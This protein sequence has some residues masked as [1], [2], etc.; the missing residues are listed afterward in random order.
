M[1]RKDENQ[2][3]SY[4]I[5]KNFEEKSVTTSGL[6]Y[7][8]II[9]AVVIVGAIVAI[10]WYVPIESLK[11]K[12]IIGLIFGVPLGAFALFGINRCSLS[13][14]LLNFLKYKLSPKIYIKKNLFV[15]TAN[16]K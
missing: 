12:I 7:R 11:V 15:K 9:E 13:E 8:N 1:A 16:K 4:Y 6:S 14:Y 3:L 2:E 5:P 10:L